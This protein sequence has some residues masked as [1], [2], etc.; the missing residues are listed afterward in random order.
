MGVR[1]TLSTSRAADKSPSV[2]WPALFQDR[3]WR[4]GLDAARPSSGMLRRYRRFFAVAAFLVLA[5][6]LLAGLIYPDGAASILMDGRTPAPAPRAPVDGADWFSLPT[7]I[8]AYLQDHI[9]LRQA[10]LRAHRELSKPL[11]GSYKILMGRGGRMFYLGNEMVVQSSGLLMRDRAVDQ[12]SDL[13][14]RMNDEL[15]ARGIRFLVAPPPNASSVYP[16]DLPVR[17]QNPGRPTEYDLL[18]AKLAVKGVPA[19]DLRSVLKTA[20]AGGSVFYLHDT[21]WTFRGAL[22]A[23]NAIVEAD[24]HADWRIEPGSALGPLAVRKGGDMATALGLSNRIWEYSEGLKLPPGRRIR[25]SDDSFIETF[26]RPGPKIL[27]FGDSLTLD[28]FPPLLLQHVGSV[29][30]VH[31][32]YC[33]FNWRVIDEIRPDEVWW[34]PGE[35]VFLCQHSPLGFPEAKTGAG[36][37]K[38]PAA[39]GRPADALEDRATVRQ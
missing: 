30:W 8:D 28:F 4:H 10:L 7:Q 35:R 22:A 13:L 15:R 5:T 37:D 2:S 6:P 12:L 17:A 23:F 26:D 21:H 14:A 29:I 16:D 11:F 18:L 31:H 27:I 20:R 38:A 36:E 9:G 34:M 24:A 3:R 19:I 32:E 25:L 1:S 33:G 39:L